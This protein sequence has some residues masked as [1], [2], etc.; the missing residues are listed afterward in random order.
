MSDRI[1]IGT[2]RF[3]LDNVTW[4]DE[5][6]KTN[7]IHVYFTHA[8]SGGM[9]DLQTMESEHVTLHGDQARLFLAAWDGD[10]I[11]PLSA[12]QQPSIASLNEDEY[13]G[14]SNPLCDHI[15]LKPDGY[16]R[17]LGPMYCS[18]ECN[19]YGK[20]HGVDRFYI[21]GQAEEEVLRCTHCGAPIEPGTTCDVCGAFMSLEKAD[22]I[23]R[24]VAIYGSGSGSVPDTI[25]CADCEQRPDS[26]PGYLWMRT[27]TEPWDFTCPTCGAHWSKQTDIPF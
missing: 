19:E 7:T 11:A 22:Q 25:L 26:E 4:V 10:A 24:A 9:E 27:D 20:Q 5:W 16:T 1:K 6:T 14:C 8:V 15:I 21:K 2:K 18:R 17:A 12:Q 13:V 23:T 3:N